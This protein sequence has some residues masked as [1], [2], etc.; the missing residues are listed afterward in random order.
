MTPLLKTE[1]LTV[2]FGG[3]NANDGAIRRETVSLIAGWLG[4]RGLTVTMRTLID[5]ANLNARNDYLFRKGLR[6]L[7]KAIAEGARVLLVW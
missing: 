3:L 1:G 5:E 4:D 6:R 7:G 2:T